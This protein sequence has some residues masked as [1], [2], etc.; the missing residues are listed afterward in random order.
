MTA[1]LLIVGG[2]LF[3]SLA[4]KYARK[5]GI[6]AL[7]FDSSRPHRASPA[8]ACT[9][10]KEWAGPFAS[11]YDEGL[12]VLSELVEVSSIGFSISIGGEEGKRNFLRA[13]PSDILE[14]PQVAAPVDCVWDGGLEA[15]GKTYSGIVY[16]AAGIWTGSLL[17]DV[18]VEGRGGLALQ[19]GGEISPRMKLWA[20]YRQAMAFPRDSGKTYF[21]DGTAHKEYDR[22]RHYYDEATI[23]RAEELFSLR[24]PTE[25]LFGYRPY[26]EGGLV[27][28][29]PSQRL[30][31]GTG[32]RKLGTLIGAYVAKKLVESL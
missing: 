28:E 1:D 7:V 10:C 17:R 14:T 15:G 9:F 27:F 13:R 32:G 20:P 22:R 18:K 24:D 5:K 30:F 19:Y 2:G 4:A 21:S 31:V 16:V 26:C 23:G 6:N 25:R 3:G 12:A 29:R 8:A 11:Y